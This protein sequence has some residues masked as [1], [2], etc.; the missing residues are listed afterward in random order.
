MKKGGKISLL[1]LAGMFFTIVLLGQAA[2]VGAQSMG[3]FTP[4]SNSGWQN[5]A[6]TQIQ[7]QDNYYITIPRE[8]FAL[9]YESGIYTVTETR[10]QVNLRGIYVQYEFN[11]VNDSVYFVPYGQIPIK[12]SAMFAQYYSP[13]G[14]WYNSKFSITFT[15]YTYINGTQGF[16]VL[17][18]YYP[19]G[20]KFQFNPEAT[21]MFGPFYP[22]FNYTKLYVTMYH[23][24][25]Y[26]QG[27]G[28]HRLYSGIGVL[29]KDAA[30]SDV[31]FEWHYARD[32]GF[33]PGETDS[34]RLELV[35]KENMKFLPCQFRASY[36]LSELQTNHPEGDKALE[37]VYLSKGGYQLPGSSTNLP[38][39]EYLTSNVTNGE[40]K[41]I[42]IGNEQQNF[43]TNFQLLE[44]TTFLA[45]FYYNPQVIN[46]TS[47]GDW[48]W[49][50]NWL[51]D[52]LCTVVN[53]VLL[54]GQFILYLFAAAFNLL[55]IVLI[56]G[57]VIPFFW[58]VVAF[59]V[60][61]GFCWVGFFIIQLIT[62]A[63]QIMPHVIMATA[64]IFSFV[65]SALVWVVTLGTIDFNT[66]L[67]TITQL[68]T[69]LASYIV[70]AIE[71][72]FAF[73][74]SLVSYVTYY[75]ILL[76]F[77]W[78]KYIYVKARGFPQRAEQLRAIYESY[79]Q[80]VYIVKNIAKEIKTLLAGWL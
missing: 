67:A 23:S 51:R 59:W 60:Y 3:F 79:L 28:S 43:T 4:W 16:K 32:Y 36:Y 44:S 45:K 42:F 1:G 73:L 71:Q 57:Q 27:V 40:N 8:N 35:R 30:R 58:N 5:S 18:Y 37:I 54:V 76:G 69:T 6:Y 13:N 2:R 50:W 22:D 72:F 61:V 31:I 49:A 39:W 29:A 75:F 11:W 41:V 48:T 66:I 77:A 24:L 47:W 7:S 80:P 64:L 65:I 46:P 78:V 15:N 55:V 19:A 63:G 33:N 38:Y 68:N 70:D 52:G 14:K 34:V 74:P 25:V 9:N 10:E 20:S 53:T 56:V 21:Q 62:W 17:Y 12:T 26:D